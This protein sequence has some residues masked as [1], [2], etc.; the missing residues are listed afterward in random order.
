MEYT[1][2]MEG[3][4]ACDGSYPEITD[5]GSVRCDGKEK[6]RRAALRMCRKH[7][8][9]EVFVSCEQGYLNRDG[10]IHERGWD[11]NNRGRYA[12]ALQVVRKNGA[13]VL[14]GNARNR[15]DAARLAKSACKRHP[16]CAIFV[17]YEDRRGIDGY[18][19]PGG[20]RHWEG[21][22]WN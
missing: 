2:F 10:K 9:R 8:G 21:H 18:L 5:A 3:K 22:A 7:P 17:I 16:K 12:Y 13:S 4:G 20:S 11:W 6:A 15:R 14:C 1:V 19:N